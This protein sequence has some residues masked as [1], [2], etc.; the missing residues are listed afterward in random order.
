MRAAEIADRILPALPRDPD[1]C[2][3]SGV[4]SLRWSA[5]L[6]QTNRCIYQVN[7][8]LVQ[9][10]ALFELVQSAVGGTYDASTE[11]TRKVLRKAGCDV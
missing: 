7:Q 10:K 11:R 5:L 6:A 2:R 3:L 1:I 4:G 8:D 9:A